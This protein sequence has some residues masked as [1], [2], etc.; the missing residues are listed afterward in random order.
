MVKLK[1]LATDTL[2][3]LR[4]S[5]EANFERYTDGAFDDLAIE[6]GWAVDVDLEI[7]AEALAGLVG[8]NETQ[9]LAVV[10]SMLVWNALKGL[11]PNLAAEERIWARL[12]HIECL[13]YARDR[14]LSDVA[15]RNQ[16]LAAIGKHFFA[17]GLPGVRDDNA[18]SR[19][20]WNAHIAR[21]A[22]PDDMVGAL[23]L[24]LKTTDYRQNLVERPSMGSRA[25]VT[26]AVLRKLAQDPWLEGQ[27]NF[28]AFMTIVN[29]LGGG[30]VFEVLEDPEID[31]FMTRCVSE[32]KVKREQTAL[33]A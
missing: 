11:T 16:R 9:E 20:W 27:D 25:C 28:R 7:D 33:A 1:A 4:S 19:L 15:G 2:D 22:W 6:N 10:N 23:R 8:K 21:L 13:S 12:C 30:I 17:R 29:R 31:T 26:A 14:W 32:A 3:Q 24:F 18:V 5:I